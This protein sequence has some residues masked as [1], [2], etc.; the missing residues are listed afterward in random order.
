MATLRE[1]VI[2]L[3]RTVRPGRRD[4]DIEE[5]LRL[6]LEMAAEHELP[7]ANSKED[8]R[9]A[10][11]IRIGGIAQGMEA[12]RDQRGLPWLTDLARDLRYGLRALRR[13]PMF[14]SVAVVTLALGIGANTAIFSLAEAVL[15]RTLPVS[16]PRELVVLR[17]IG[18]NGDIFP[19]TSA[20]AVDLAGSRDV[21]SGLAA[22]RPWLDTH[23]SV[24][25]ET[26][27]ALVQWVSSNYHALLGTRAVLGRTLIEQDREPIAVISHRYWQ[28]RFGGDPNV[29]GRAFEMQGRSFTIVGVTPPEFFGTQPG[30]Y[31]DVTAPLTAQTRTMPPNARWLYLVGRLAPGVSREQA[32]AALRVRWTELTG[33]P[34]APSRPPV[35]LELDSG[36]Q[37]MNELRREFSVPLRILMAT[38]AVV[39]LV[40]CANLGGLLIARSSARRQEMAI[41]LSLGA[42]RGRIV[43]Q[44]LT[45]S[46]LLAVAGGAAGVTLSYWMSGLLLAMMSRGRGH[47][48]LDLAP[49]LPTL[50]FAAAVT[51]VTAVLF[52]LL[53]ALGASR[54]D[55]QPR[56]KRSGNADRTRT[57]WSRAMVAAQVALL[58]LLLASAGLFA[59][60]LQKLRAVDVGFRQDQVLVVGVSPGPA[61]R[62]ESAR[63]LYDELYARI[64]ALPAVQSVSLS[65][66]S[67]GGDLS[68]AAGMS[69]PGR[70]ADAADAPPVYHNFVGPRF[71]E[72][73]GIPVLAGR[74]FAIKDDERAPKYV[75][76]NESVARRYFRDDDPIGRQILVGNP[77][78]QRCPTPAMASIIGVVKDVRYS[79]LRTAAPLMIYRPYLQETSA[80]AGAFLIRTSSDS[81]EALTSALRAEIRRAAPGLPPP[82]IVSLDDRVAAMVVEERMLATLSS[83]IGMLAAILAA[84]G[85]YS[86]VASAVARR[87]REI[88]VRM[89]LGALPGQVARMV[90]R[91]AFGI[92]AGGLA[93]GIPA[94][95]A[96][97]LAARS[98]LAG[99]LFELSPTDPLILLSSTAAI[100]LIASLAAYLPARRAARIDPVA[101]LRYE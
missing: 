36:A 70:P 90:V 83:A 29:V 33:A 97:A 38:V 86:A 45:E 22:F 51:L 59:R 94:A 37:G 1:W 21:L 47:I 27:L 14:T 32:R 72:T 65:M 69:V 85:I 2:R 95:F 10:A 17:Q 57:A 53:P 98:L 20:A 18:P 31:I 74:D 81:S 84:V 80:P 11:V 9:R 13:N 60:S 46:T 100:L 5:E 64:G 25:S 6:H 67:P 73:M 40:A 55:V 35:T 93:L 75:V 44:L 66:D 62:G 89:A 101:S 15:L 41:R 50:A 4:A 54:T 87:Q 8:A 39:L 96:A 79:S 88:G 3:W 76:I 16:N 42:A 49:N 91:D 78:C 63:A 99:V 43:R 30:R 7:R 23:V 19:F 92:V 68:M 56:L 82:S 12:A 58:V 52:G 24:N 34:S 61:Y 77:G 28:R 26:E 48:A 71:F